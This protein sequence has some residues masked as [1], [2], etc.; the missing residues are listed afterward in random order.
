M[1]HK[2]FFRH[3]P[4]RISTKERDAESTTSH[5]ISTF[6]RENLSLA[7]CSSAEPASVSVQRRQ[8]NIP[9]LTFTASFY[10]YGFSEYTNKL[11]NGQPY[12]GMHTLPTAN[13]QLP[14]IPCRLFFPNQM[15]PN[16]TSQ[17]CLAGVKKINWHLGSRQLTFV[18]SCARGRLPLTSFSPF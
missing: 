6:C 14:T 2:G 11:K 10:T 3:K 13:C 16:F 8:D 17:G 9:L 15:L 1:Q 12:S 7:G 18:S 4:S 5:S